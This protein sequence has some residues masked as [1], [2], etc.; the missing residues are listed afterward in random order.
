MPKKTSDRRKWTHEEVRQWYRET[1]AI[2]Y[3]NPQDLNVVVPK[4]RGNGMT[5]N[6]ANPKAYLLQGLILVVVFLLL[7]LGKAL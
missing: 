5:V 6:W 2:T 4:P 3:D 7:F 1:G